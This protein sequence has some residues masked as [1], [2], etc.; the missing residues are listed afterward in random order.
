MFES[1]RQAVLAAT[2]LAAICGE[3][4]TLDGGLALPVGIGIDAGPAVPVVDGYRGGAVNTAARLCSQAG[5]GQVLVTRRIAD[6]AGDVP[7]V[8]LTSA[9][10]AELKGLEGQLE[11]I[12]AV[13]TLGKP[14]TTSAAAGNLAPELEDDTPI[15]GRES[16]LSRWLRGCWRRAARGSGRV[17]VI[18]GRAGIGKT[19]LAAEIARHVDATGALRPVRGRAAEP[20]GGRR[21]RDA[22]SRASP[23]GGPTLVV[24]DDL[25]ATGD[26]TPAAVEELLGEIEAGSTLVV[27]LLRDPERG[28]AAGRLIDAID[29]YGDGHRRL[30]GIDA[31]G[32]HEIARAYAGNDIESVPLESI[33]RSSHGI[34]ARVHGPASANAEQTEAT[35]RLE[36]AAEFLASERRHR[37]SGLEFAGTVIGLKLGRL[38]REDGLRP[39]DT[40]RSP[41]KGLASFGADDA[42]LFFGRE[43]LVGE[44][45]ARSVGTGLLAVVGASG[46]G[47]SSVIAAGLLPSLRAGLLPGSEHWETATI[48]PGEALPPRLPENGARLVLVVD[49]FEELFTI[50]AEEERSAFVVRLV[51]LSDDPERAVVVLSI[52][53]DFYGHCGAYPRL[54]RLLADNQVLVGPMAPEE[55][56]ARSSYLPAAAAR[57]STRPSPTSSSRRSAAN[58]AGYRSSRRRSPSS[59]AGATAAG[60]RWRSTRR[61]AASAARS[62]VSPRPPTSSSTR[63]GATPPAASSCGSSCS[64]TK[65][66][67]YGAASRRQSSTSRASRS[68]RRSSPA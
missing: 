32:V 23:P 2:E 64:G 42:A 31:Q 47:K 57:A 15:A 12:E 65:A 37:S 33:G 17:L 55:P 4:P 14:S 16:G 9:G 50:L 41:Y 29:G 49:Q 20:C 53:G 5:G 43:Q 21:G 13:G 6:M 61:S 10:S 54:A 45:A 22:Q 11:L 63:T 51:E 25:D 40:G 1:A 68:W 19:R 38:Y 46:S 36:A 39:M 28:S 66:S 24:L 62:R 26:T 44:L 18:S 60:S 34:P 3:E 30:A 48:R 67:S 59:G 52:R 8:R 7:G 58:R 56:G 35:R 27:C